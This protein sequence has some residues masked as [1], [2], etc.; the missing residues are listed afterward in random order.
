MKVTV[1]KHHAHGNRRNPATFIAKIGETGW[2]ASGPTKEIALERL[3][4][5][6]TKEHDEQFTRHYRRK[7]VVTFCLYYAQG[8]TYDIVRDGD[9]SGVHG[10]CGTACTNERE[11]LAQMESHVAQ[12]DG[13]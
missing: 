7:G 4:Q 12:H 13:V 1:E 5:L 6:L 10:S 2:Q 3:E 9:M 11:A 8:W